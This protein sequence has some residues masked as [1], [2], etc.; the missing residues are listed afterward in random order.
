MKE[1]GTINEIIIL[2]IGADTSQETI[3]TGL[4]MGGDR[5]VL[6]KTNGNDIDPLNIGKI[7]KS[8]FE[9]SLQIL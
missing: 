6:V 1:N 9:K 7:I 2:S 4:A 8:I 3:R 5:G